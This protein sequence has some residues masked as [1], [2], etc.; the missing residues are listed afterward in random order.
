MGSALGDFFKKR[1]LIYAS[2]GADDPIG[3]KNEMA[4]PFVNAR[5]FSQLNSPS[6]GQARAESYFFVVQLVPDP[7]QGKDH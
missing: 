2:Y 6:D 3:I 1:A 7:H 4:A 5:N